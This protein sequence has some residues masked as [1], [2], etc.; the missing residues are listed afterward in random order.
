[1]KVSSHAI[2]KFT[3]LEHPI[4][5]K[6]NRLREPLPPIKEKK[7]LFFKWKVDLF[8]AAADKNDQDFSF[9]YLSK[10][11]QLFRKILSFAF[12]FDTDSAR[13]WKALQNRGAV[14][15]QVSCPKNGFRKQL[16]EKLA[17]FFRE[18]VIE[19]Q[20]SGINKQEEKIGLERK[21]AV[22]AGMKE[23]SDYWSD[24]KISSENP[25]G[26][27]PIS[28][29]DQEARLN[30][31]KEVIFIVQDRLEKAKIPFWLDAGTAL[32]VYRFGDKQLPHDYDADICIP[33]AYT[34]QV[35]EIF[36]D[37]VKSNPDK[38][39]FD[40]IM[41]DEPG[42]LLR[43]TIKGL[44]LPAWLGVDTCKFEGDTLKMSYDAVKHGDC[45]KEFVFPL[46]KSK[47]YDGEVWMPNQPEAYLKTRYGNLEP[48]IYWDPVDKRNVADL[49]HKDIDTVRWRVHTADMP[50]VYIPASVE[51]SR[52]IKKRSIK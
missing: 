15:R 11:E 31:F 35:A 19:N 24:E 21:N 5:C 50:H 45:R 30:A 9:V 26:Y 27:P 47:F 13:V 2:I 48:L 12:K 51:E 46:K 43:L 32:G 6:A 3:D 44:N 29:P 16:N 8:V 49:E 28:H 52:E 33:Y 22:L 4:D 25:F 38:Y 14:D 41:A 17:Q 20:L 36:I 7:L 1:M 34:K 42:Y 40:D 18:N 39:E 37:M 23:D 10:F